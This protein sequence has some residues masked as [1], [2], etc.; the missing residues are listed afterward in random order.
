M[1]YLYSLWKQK[2]SIFFNFWDFVISLFP[3]SITLIG[4]YCWKY[5]AN[6]QYIDIYLG[7]GIQTFEDCPV[8]AE[9]SNTWRGMQQYRLILTFF[10]TPRPKNKYLEKTGKLHLRLGTV[11]SLMD[12]RTELRFCLLQ[13]FSPQ[14]AVLQFTHVWEIFS[15]TDIKNDKKRVLMYLHVLLIFWKIMVYHD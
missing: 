4:F 2:I 5:Q 7:I 6:P 13:K 10:N 9:F 3:I 8:L 11:I 15:R 1:L 12:W 14:T